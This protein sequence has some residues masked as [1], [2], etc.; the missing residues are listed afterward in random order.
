M[1]TYNT[2]SSL[3]LFITPATAGCD[4]FNTLAILY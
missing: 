3:F 2:T 4:I 1:I